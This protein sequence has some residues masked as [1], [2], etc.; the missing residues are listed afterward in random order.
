MVQKFAALL[1][2]NASFSLA[3]GTG[4]ADP[5]VPPG[6]VLLPQPEK[7][8]AIRQ[9][10]RRIFLMGTRGWSYRIVGKKEGQPWK[11]SHVSTLRQNRKPASLFGEAGIKTGGMDG[12][13]TRDLLRDRQTL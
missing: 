9:R 5:A 12:T 1:L 3:A 2:T 8:A 13:R 7:A 4:A 11:C 10:G 6:G